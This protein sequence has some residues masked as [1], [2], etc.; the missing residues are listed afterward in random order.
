MT[1]SRAAGHAAIPDFAAPLGDIRVHK[2]PEEPLAGWSGDDRAIANRLVAT[3]DVTEPL[4]EAAGEGVI[5]LA[6]DSRVEGSGP[7]RSSEELLARMT[8]DFL[9]T[10]W[11]DFLMTAWRGTPREFRAAALRQ[12]AAV[13]QGVA[14]RFGPS[15]TPS[16][17]LRRSSFLEV[18]PIGHGR[19]LGLVS[20]R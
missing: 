9:M 3:Q 8:P 4:Y 16:T 19:R 14:F 1:T 13:L 18:P 10:A 20:Q 6:V 15:S 12:Q 2:F 17:G 5:R 11:R 7:C